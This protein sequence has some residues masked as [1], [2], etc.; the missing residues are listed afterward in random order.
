M[1][2]LA[3]TLGAACLHCYTLLTLVVSTASVILVDGT[4]LAGIVSCSGSYYSC[5]QQVAIVL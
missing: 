2:A 1:L 3:F 5:R 4:K